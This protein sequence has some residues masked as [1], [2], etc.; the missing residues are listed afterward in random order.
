MYFEWSFGGFGLES[1]SER[2]T[3][4]NLAS[5]PDWDWLETPEVILGR[6]ADTWCRPAV[7]NKQLQPFMT[8]LASMQL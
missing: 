6:Q 2:K 1:K 4:P 5:L 7:S 3:E 8:E